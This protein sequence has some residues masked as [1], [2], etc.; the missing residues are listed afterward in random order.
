MSTGRRFYVLDFVHSPTQPWFVY[1][2]GKWESGSGLAHAIRIPAPP[3]TVYI[4]P[5]RTRVSD[6]DQPVSLDSVRTEVLNAVG[7]TEHATW[8]QVE[9]IYA[10]QRTI[11]RDLTLANPHYGIPEGTHP[12]WK[13]TYPVS[14]GGWPEEYSTERG[15]GDTFSHIFGTTW[16]VLERAKLE[17]DSGAPGWIRVRDVRQ[18]NERV[19]ELLGDP[20]T[21]LFREPLSWESKDS[22][23]SSSHPPPLSILS[24]QLSWNG[25]HI[26]K[27]DSSWFVEQQTTTPT[28][29]PP[30]PWTNLDAWLAW[31][32]SPG[33]EIDVVVCSGIMQV[34]KYLFQQCHQRSVLYVPAFLR[35]E[36][37]LLNHPRAAHSFLFWGRLVLDP[38]ALAKTWYLTPCPSDTNPDALWSWCQEQHQLLTHTRYM[39]Q[40]CQCSW[41][42]ALRGYPSLA[43]ESMLV[44]RLEKLGWILP[45]VKQTTFSNVEQGEDEA[46]QAPKYEYEGGTNLKPKCGWHKTPTAL[47]DVRSMYPSIVREHNIC[48]STLPHW[49]PTPDERAEYL[50]CHPASRD[51]PRGAL[52][53][54][55][56]Y[57]IQMRERITDDAALNKVVKTAANS[58]YGLL[59]SPYFRFYS[60]FLADKIAEY[61]RATLQVLLDI[62]RS[63]VS[64]QGILYGVTDSIRL[65]L[66]VQPPSSSSTTALLLADAAKQIVDS[67]N[68]QY[69]YIKVKLESVSDQV[70]LFA[71]N[72][73]VAFT[74]GRELDVTGVEHVSHNAAPILYNTT[75]QLLQFLFDHPS[76]K[77]PDV[78]RKAYELIQ[79]A[80]NVQDSKE[81]TMQQVLHTD[82]FRQDR[83]FVAKNVRAAPQYQVASDYEKRHP[84]AKRWCV[85]ESVPFVLAKKRGDGNVKSGPDDELTYV[86]PEQVDDGTWLLDRRGFLQKR[87]VPLWSRL[88]AY[89]PGFNDAQFQDWIW[90]TGAQKAVEHL[91][92]LDQVE[93]KGVTLAHQSTPSLSQDKTKQQDAI[94][95]LW[96]LYQQNNILAFIDTCV[97]VSIHWPQY[98]LELVAV[99][100]ETA[101][102]LYYR[103]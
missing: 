52:P 2:V 66:P 86:H 16:T 103:S 8:E 11:V 68:T 62:S 27:I 89:V 91:S 10:F 65:T 54:L 29:P 59:A 47:V 99:H 100:P 50:Q 12:Y 64:E 61:G 6:P 37:R 40:V 87:V 23:S 36:L 53:Q 14:F 95:K 30:P 94:Q 73:F 56:D 15:G 49:L 74:Q 93:W 17:I 20:K 44:H 26:S 39:A 69:S 3:R 21:C 67:F 92:F 34:Q 42:D 55:M 82:K 96:T 28:S 24:I 101:S 83:E 79:G 4:L 63:V 43:A 90:K 7:F 88:L 84:N 80:L 22:S 57:M 72:K 38:Y 5:R 78:Y 31:L 58:I 51:R 85:K 102:W 76:V 71:K 48:F 32:D 9:R 33:T 70:L 13:L 18:S 1:L 75:Q 19:W 97:S 35:E 25:S 45:E 77:A 81:W 41:N 98:H 46:K 60:P